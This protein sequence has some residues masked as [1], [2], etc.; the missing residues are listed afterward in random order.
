MLEQWLALQRTWMHLEPIF[1]SADIQQQLPN[2]SKRY[3]T[4][5]RLWRKV[6][7]STR[8]NPAVLKA[9]GSQRLLLQLQEANRVLESVQKGLAD[10]L[11]TKRL[12]FARHV[13]CYHQ[14]AQC[15]LCHDV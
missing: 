11:E 3:A 12:A 1:S 15:H 5:D 4:V 8:R 9:A 13:G 7:E 10:Y 14:A 6:L 2:E